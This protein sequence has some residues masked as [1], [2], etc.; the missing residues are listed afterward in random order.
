[1]KRLT[2]IDEA[3]LASFADS[4]ILFPACA[5]SC[6]YSSSLLVS[7]AGECERDDRFEQRL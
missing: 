6:W 4:F 3:E 1:M 7:S 2:G 5:Q